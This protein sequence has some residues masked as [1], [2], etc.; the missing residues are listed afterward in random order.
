M[1]PANSSAAQ[2]VDSACAL[3]PHDE[4]PSPHHARA[5]KSPPKKKPQSMYFFA[6]LRLCMDCTPRNHTADRWKRPKGSLSFYLPKDVRPQQRPKSTLIQ[7][8]RIQ[9]QGHAAA[10]VEL[11]VNRLH[12]LQFTP[13]LNPLS[14]TKLALRS[15]RW[16]PSNPC[17]SC[18]SRC[19]A[20]HA[21]AAPKHAADLRLCA[22]G[23][24]S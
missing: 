5:A 15:A 7:T 22:H 12:R 2:R 8:K 3:I 13:A 20:L 9:P 17:G 18:L 23:A 4:L 6:V 16:C 21:C 1:P 14:R 19:A 24:M 11:E 10:V